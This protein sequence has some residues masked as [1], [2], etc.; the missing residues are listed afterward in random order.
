MPSSTDFEKPN[1]GFTAYDAKDPD[2][3]IRPIQI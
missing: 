3:A 1:A 2:S